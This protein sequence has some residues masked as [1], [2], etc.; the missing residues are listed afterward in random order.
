MAKRNIRKSSH[1]CLSQQSEDQQR[2]ETNK[3]SIASSI[4]KPLAPLRVHGVLLI[5]SKHHVSSTDL[6]SSYVFS[7]HVS[8]SADITLL[9]TPSLRKPQEATTYHQDFFVVV[10]VLFVCLFVCFLVCFSLWSPDKGS[11]TTQWKADQKCISLAK[12]LHHLFIY[13]FILIKYPFTCVYFNKIS[14]QVSTLIKCPLIYVH[15][16]KT[17]LYMLAPTKHHDLLSKEP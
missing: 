5:P 4:G 8:V 16:K 1:L 6:A 11:S 15:F 10:V 12:I 9:I 7:Q 14:L 13:M 17:F 3:H 2:H